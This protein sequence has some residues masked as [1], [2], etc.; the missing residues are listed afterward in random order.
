M[1]IRLWLIQCLQTTGQPHP[2]SP[3]MTLLVWKKSHNQ[4]YLPRMSQLKIQEK[5]SSVSHLQNLFLSTMGYFWVFFN[6]I[7]DRKDL[8][9]AQPCQWET[10][11]ARSPYL[12]TEWPPMK[13][14]KGN[15]KWSQ[16]LGESK[17][18]QLENRMAGE[19]TA[20]VGWEEDTSTAWRTIQYCIPGPGRRTENRRGRKRAAQ[21]SYC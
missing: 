4:R 21:I 6:H 19:E 11:W 7:E 13:I 8:G 3:S 16:C 5:L 2:G 9:W 12:P 14:N 20:E 10:P 1:G 15:D 17:E 18:H